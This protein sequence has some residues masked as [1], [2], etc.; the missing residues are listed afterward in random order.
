VGEVD[1]GRLRASDPHESARGA[2]AEVPWG[3][4]G[5]EGYR[6]RGIE[7]EEQLTGGGP[8]VE[9]RCYTGRGHKGRAWEASCGE[10]ELLWALAEAGVQQGGR[11]T[12][13]QEARC[14]GAS[15]RWR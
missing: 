15:G 11:P 6:R 9:F 1:A 7:G 10:A 8:R 2:P 4:R 14:G 12:A 5:L 13:E 3:L